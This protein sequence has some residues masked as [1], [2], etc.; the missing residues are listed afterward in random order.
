MS[1]MQMCDQINYH[2]KQWYTKYLISER[3]VL[4][5]LNFYDFR[6]ASTVVH[7]RTLHM[8]ADGIR[9]PYTRTQIIF[10]SYTCK[11]NHK[12]IFIYYNV[13]EIWLI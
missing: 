9:L 2:N 8:N 3:K 10:S 6:L 1:K 5:K 4:K 13:L 12:I 7:R 11:I